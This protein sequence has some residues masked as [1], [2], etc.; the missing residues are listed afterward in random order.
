MLNVN[1]LNVTGAKQFKFQTY[2]GTQTVRFAN[3]NHKL[4]IVY[5]SLYSG[6]AYLA[7][8][9]S[10]YN[11]A[12]TKGEVIFSPN[13][14]IA[15]ITHIDNYVDEITVVAPDGYSWIFGYFD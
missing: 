12:A 10:N 1:N 5:S 7:F 4:G 2:I 14:H 11:V 15:N 9:C 3:S 8:I 6:C 13:L